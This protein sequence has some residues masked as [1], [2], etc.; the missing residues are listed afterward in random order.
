MLSQGGLQKQHP[1]ELR[2][3]FYLLLHPLK[4]QMATHLSILAQKIPWT[5]EPGG[6][7]ST[8]SQRVSY[9]ELDTQQTF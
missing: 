5:E 9:K 6:L 8:A 3:F 4:K 7:Q 1:A 2:D